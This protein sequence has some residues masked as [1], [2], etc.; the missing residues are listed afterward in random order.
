MIKNS[1]TIRIVPLGLLSIVC[2]TTLLP[3][4]AGCSPMGGGQPVPSREVSV[5]PPVSSVQEENSIASSEDGD[6]DFRVWIKSL[7]LGPSFPNKD[8]TLTATVDWAPQGRPVEVDY[9]WFING[10]E[11]DEKERLPG[12][13]STLP[14]ERF[15]SGDR[16]Y[17]IVSLIRP[18]G[19][20]AAS[21]RS[22]SKVIQNRAPRFDSA[23]EHLSREGSALVGNIGYS[24]P[25]GDKVTVSLVKGPEGMIVETDGRVRW[26]ISELK[27]GNH[28]ITLELVD[29]RGLGFRGTFPFSLGIEDEIKN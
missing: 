4:L 7:V 3:S 18:D 22:R 13:P 28:E 29:E 23:L 12:K 14:L 5:S 9:R 17:V 8:Q 20:V 11:I 24:D 10:K 16:V 1:L 19:G 25:D 27:R 2:M 21:R 6:S 26:P 15:R